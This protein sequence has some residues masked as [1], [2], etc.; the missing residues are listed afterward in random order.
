MSTI[1]RYILLIMEALDGNCLPIQSSRSSD[2][3][4]NNF[5]ALFFNVVLVIGQYLY[6]D[7]LA[8]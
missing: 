2:A 5:W 4:L 7:D 1:R 8:S 3:T 6:N